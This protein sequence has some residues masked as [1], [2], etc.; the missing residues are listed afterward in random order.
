MKQYTQTGLALDFEFFVDSECEAIGPA[1]DRDIQKGD[2]VSVGEDGATGVVYAIAS[3]HIAVVLFG[4][5]DRAVFFPLDQVH[6]SQNIV[7]SQSLEKQRA[8]T[9]QNEA[10][11]QGAWKERF[12]RSS[13]GKRTG[14][15]LRWRW[16]DP[17]TGKKRS[18][19]IGKG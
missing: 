13:G 2:V 12:Y 5:L 11:P 4:Q 8:V 17:K 10:K 1:V 14:P 6:R 15:Y 16:R 7:A 9:T 18:K 3:D 19:Y